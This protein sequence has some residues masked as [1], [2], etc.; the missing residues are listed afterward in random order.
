MENDL[1][2]IVFDLNQP[3]NITRVALAS[4]SARCISPTAPVGGAQHEQR[5]PHRRGPQDG[6]APSRRWSAIS[7][8]IRTG[9]PPPSL[10]E[11][12]HVDYYGTPDAAQPAGRHQ[13]P[14]AA[15]DRHPAV[16]PRRPRRDR[17]GDPEERHRPHAERRR[18]GR[19]PQHPAPDRG[20]SQGPR[21]AV[22][23]SAWRR[24]GSRSATCAARR[25][26][27]SRRKSATASVGAD[28]VH[29]ELEQLQKTTDRYI[30]EV[31]R[32]GAAKE[33]EVLEV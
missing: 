29:R 8:A 26:T 17:E 3:D 32:V 31:D 10:V 19:S 13:R 20:A 2:I 16:G 12:I 30:A 1:P 21:Q 25:P 27:R 23:T 4:R 9:A 7:R 6:A 24:R 5:D 15:P 18:H 33:Q 28:E 11:R 22:S 14:R